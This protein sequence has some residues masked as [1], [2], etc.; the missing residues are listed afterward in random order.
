MRYWITLLTL[1]ALSFS[2]WAGDFASGGIEYSLT[3]HHGEVAVDARIVDGLNAY[4]GTCLIPSTVTY[5][6]ESYRVTAIAPGAFAHS[7]VTEVVVPNSVTRI[8][9]SAFADNAAIT[10]VTIPNTVTTL[11]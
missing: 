2:G 11:P 9:E 5:G 10:A 1:A 4:E 6:G 8:G 3:G 7:Q